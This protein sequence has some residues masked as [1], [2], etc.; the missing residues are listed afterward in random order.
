LGYLK[1]T[2]LK[3]SALYILCLLFGLISCEGNTEQ[4]IITPTLQATIN[5]EFQHFEK[6]KAEL[7]EGFITIL[8]SEHSTND[9][10]NTFMITVNG[11]KPG[12]YVQSYD[13]RTGVSITQCRMV[14]RMNKTNEL[15]YYISFEGK[16]K[17]AEI[18]YVNKTINGSF[19]FR[20]RNGNTNAIEVEN[21]TFNNIPF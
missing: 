2:I 12:D 19:Q 14:Y 9:G 16:V 10:A 4:E 5:A 13:P 3:I 15:T 11:N 7:K 6:K 8:S 20:L 1:W 18:D 17:L 21:G